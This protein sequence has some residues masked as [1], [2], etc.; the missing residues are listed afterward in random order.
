MYVGLSMLQ[1]RCA[2]G[3]EMQKGRLPRDSRPCLYCHQVFHNEI[4]N[5]FIRTK[6]CCLA[7][8]MGFTVHLRT[9][10]IVHF[11]SSY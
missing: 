5:L 4:A 10:K 3:M 2:Y 9:S 11:N 1:P 6:M 8:L 7:S